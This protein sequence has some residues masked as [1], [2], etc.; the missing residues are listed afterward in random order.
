MSK[1][2]N[3]LEQ[4]ELETSET[5][6]A[7]AVYYNSDK[8]FPSKA[9]SASGEESIRILAQGISRVLDNDNLSGNVSSLD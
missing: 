9:V 4:A 7:T 3:L 1:Q 5:E 8:A 6:V 2:R